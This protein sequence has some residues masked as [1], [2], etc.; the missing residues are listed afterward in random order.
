MSLH[1]YGKYYK[2]HD[3]YKTNLTLMKPIIIVLIP[4]IIITIM[5]IIMINIIISLAQNYKQ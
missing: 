3:D 1:V 2:Q 4:L 5:V